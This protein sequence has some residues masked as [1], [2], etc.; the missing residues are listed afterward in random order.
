[1]DNDK[2]AAMA[3]EA[4]RDPPVFI[5]AMF[6]IINGYGIW[7]EENSGRALEACLMSL[8]ILPSFAGVPLER[9]SQLAASAEPSFSLY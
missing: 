3:V 7:I 1:M 8:Q 6:V 2:Q 4:K 9:I 5:L